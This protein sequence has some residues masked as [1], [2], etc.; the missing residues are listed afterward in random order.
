MRD[1]WFD[2]GS[3]LTLEELSRAAALPPEWV[4]ERVNAGLIE[5]ADEPG[6]PGRWRFEAVIVRRVRSMHH[7]E[8]CFGAVPE[9]AAL[10]AD[11]EDEIA[12]LRAALA[13]TNW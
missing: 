13:R 5:P 4:A 1:E 11:L 6:G 10:V 2:P 9:L 7:T 3:L 8:R 12:Q